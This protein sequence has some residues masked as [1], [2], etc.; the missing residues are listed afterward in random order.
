MFDFGCTTERGALEIE[1]AVRAII[2][3]T[4]LTML[5]VRRKRAEQNSSKEAPNSDYESSRHLQSDNQRAPSGL[6]R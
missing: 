4:M 3:Q 2:A 1:E 6:S 5:F